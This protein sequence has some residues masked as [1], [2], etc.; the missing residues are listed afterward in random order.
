M[1]TFL[2]TPRM[3]PA[4]RARVERAVS[5]RERAKHHAA[6]IGLKSPF[7][8][9]GPVR[10]ARVL[11]LV[12]LLLVVG[13]GS[14]TYVHENRMMEDERAALLAALEERRAGLPA[15]HEGFVAKIDPWIAEAA[16]Q[17]AAVDVIDPSLQ[18]PGALDAWLGRPA[19]YVRGAAA[20]LRDPGKRDNA[21][22]ASIKD[23]F[24]F[25]LMTP[26]ASATPGALLEK[27]R[28]VY[29]GGSKVEEQTANVRRLAEAQVGL[30]VLGNAF[31]GAVRAAEEPLALKKLRKDLQSAPTDEAKQ[32]AAAELLI[33]VADET[34]VA[35]ARAARVSLVD[36]GSGKPLLRARLH[37]TP[38]GSSASAALHRAALEGCGLALSLRSSVEE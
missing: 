28:G 24:L 33:V 6:K 13:L 4:L 23:A 21:A 34:A 14:A 37:V 7:A 31:E 22:G 12:A 1:A 19:V 16:A 36:L 20:E 30:A 29:F 8:S 35:G 17:S 18:E 27:V 11:P 15:G 9:R 5:H 38:A 32:A 26:P 2:T 3:N 10:L 25:C